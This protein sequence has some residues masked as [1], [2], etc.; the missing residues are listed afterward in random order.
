MIPLREFIRIVLTPPDLKPKIRSLRIFYYQFKS[1]P[2]SS[3]MR[4]V[5]NFIRFFVGWMRRPKQKSSAGKSPNFLKVMLYT[6]KRS[7][8]PATGN[9]Y[10]TLNLVLYALRRKKAPPP[11]PSKTPNVLMQALKTSPRAPSPGIRES[12]RRYLFILRRMSRPAPKGPTPSERQ[13][14]TRKELFLI[15]MRKD[16]VQ[17][18]TNTRLILSGFST[19]VLPHWGKAV[20]VMLLFLPVLEIFLQFTSLL[21]W[22]L[23]KLKETPA[24]RP[25]EFVVMCVGDS[26]TAG[27][28]SSIQMPPYVKFVSEVLATKKSR[29]W[30][31]INFSSEYLTSGDVLRRTQ[32]L[33]QKQRPD[34]VYLMIGINDI[35][36]QDTDKIVQSPQPVTVESVRP[37]FHI[38]ILH[39]KMGDGFSLP[40]FLDVLVIPPW[41][42][43]EKPPIAGY[44]PEYLA[45]SDS[46]LDAMVATSKTAPKTIKYSE[47]YAA[48]MEP[49][50][51][52]WNL[53]KN[54]VLTAARQEFQK[55]LQTN[56]EDVIARAGL[57]ETYYELGM[58]SEARA[59]ISWLQ[60]NYNKN[61]DYKNARAL[62][63]AFPFENTPN[64]TSEIA[65]DLLKKFP[66]DPWFWKSLATACLLSSRPDYALRGIDRALDLSP[67]E[68]PEWKAIVFRTRAGIVVRTNPD[69]ALQNLMQAF[70][71]DENE[72][73]FIAALRKNG[74]HYL[75]TNLQKALQT[76]SCP[77]TTKENLAA[78]YYQALDKKLIYTLFALET[79]LRNIVLRC[80]EYKVHP[81]LVGYP[82]PNAEIDQINRRVAEE[83]GAS[84]LN[85]SARFEDMLKTDT[86]R[87]FMREGRYTNRA[88]RKL[89]EWIAND[90]A[91]RLIPQ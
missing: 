53:L 87:K 7:K 80:Q 14:V 72:D 18:K 38:E 9:K 36:V 69:Q 5:R 78:L 51:P 33:V 15:Q 84:W 26:F 43:L 59:E 35:A 62:L 37:P 61:P 22:P 55:Y 70:L 34:L 50:K 23:I 73:L 16:A 24:A 90:A 10:K 20:V 44:R 76:I 56:S 77:T 11:E 31:V 67:A 75:K 19:K 40:D 66:A 1:S 91:G 88:G 54:G 27:K 71:L 64:D 83:T 60:E 48:L 13:E 89:A 49:Q 25:G 82:F 81:V 12:L 3:P 63:H 46:R 52:V 30:K 85:L 4:S 79:R 2:G 32:D 29:N 8:P 6:L 86:E 74:L 58:H 65:V 68:L 47:E 28:F 41:F 21:A 42:L 17:I 39:Q 57:T 45:V